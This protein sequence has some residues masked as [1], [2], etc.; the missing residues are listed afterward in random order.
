MPIQSQRSTIIFT[1]STIYSTLSESVVAK[2]KLI[3]TIKSSDKI[4]KNKKVKQY[5]CEYV[6]KKGIYAGTITKKKNHI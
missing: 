1:A 3:G 5:F 2:E 4:I 6:T